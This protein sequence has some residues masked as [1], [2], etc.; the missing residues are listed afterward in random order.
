MHLCKVEMELIFEKNRIYACHESEIAKPDGSGSRTRLPA[1]S[2]LR[3]VHAS[4]DAHGSSLYEG[5]FRYPV[6]QLYF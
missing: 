3:T 6:S 1:P 2:P 5:T 4:F